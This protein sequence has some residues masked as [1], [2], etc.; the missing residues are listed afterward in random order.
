MTLIYDLVDKVF[1]FILFRDEVIINL[2]ELHF[3]VKI[4]FCL[5]LESVRMEAI[6]FVV[7][8][9]GLFIY[10]VSLIKN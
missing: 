2:I 3:D 1:A 9:D 6:K 8:N 4:T 5:F 7:L 10:E